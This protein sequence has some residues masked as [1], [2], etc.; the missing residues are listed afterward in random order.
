MR[1]SVRF[2]GKRTSVLDHPGKLFGDKMKAHMRLD[3]AASTLNQHYTQ[4]QT[5]HHIILTSSHH[6]ILIQHLFS[7]TFITHQT[8]HKPTKSRSR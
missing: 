7:L 4:H 5:L 1:D 3:I 2:H 8:S 6:Q